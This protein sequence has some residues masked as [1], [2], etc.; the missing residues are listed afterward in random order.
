MLWRMAR[1]RLISSANTSSKHLAIAS[2]SLLAHASALER[3]VRAA[4][5][6]RVVK[7]PAPV[8]AGP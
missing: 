6:G 3:A 2:P 1:I 4:R 5:T 8:N 7:V